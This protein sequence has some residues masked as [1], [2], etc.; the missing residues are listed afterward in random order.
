MRK[1]ILLSLIIASIIGSCTQAKKSPLEGA[2]KIVEYGQWH[3][4]DTSLKA[5]FNNG[6]IKMWSKDYF[7]FVGYFRPDT[8]IHQYHGAGI[9]TLNGNKYEEYIIY[10][11]YKPLVGTK[12]KALLEIRNDTLIQRYNSDNTDSWELRDGFTTERYIRLK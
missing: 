7:A 9:Y 3:I 2:W 1:V 10:N 5:M 6:L 12:F 11:D 8:S 4:T